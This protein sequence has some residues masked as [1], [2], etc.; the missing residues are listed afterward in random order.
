MLMVLPFWIR[1]RVTGH[2]KQ[3][4]VFEGEDKL[5]M[6][7]KHVPS[8]FFSSHTR[9]PILL[10]ISYLIDGSS[11]LTSPFTILMYKQVTHN[12]FMTHYEIFFKIHI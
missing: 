8:K 11:S 12:S 3:S 7:N 6:A 2:S 9:M 10:E 5:C 1:F 4:V